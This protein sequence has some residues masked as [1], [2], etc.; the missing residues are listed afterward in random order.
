M[1]VCFVTELCSVITAS[2][3]KNKV[4]QVDSVQLPYSGS[5]TLEVY[6]VCVCSNV[7]SPQN[8]F[9]SLYINI[10]VY[11]HKHKVNKGC[12][13]NLPENAIGLLEIYVSML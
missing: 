12:L 6:R 9:L 13:H 2:W 4:A 8:Y 5:Q 1:K 7:E 3:Q 11:I 10:Y